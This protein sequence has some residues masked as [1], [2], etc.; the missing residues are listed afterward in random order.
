M[1]G[2]EGKQQEAERAWQQSHL[3]APPSFPSHC[4]SW[5][6]HTFSWVQQPLLPGISVFSKEFAQS[7]PNTAQPHPLYPGTQGQYLTLSLGFSSLMGVITLS[8]TQ[9]KAKQTGRGP[10]C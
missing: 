4:G 3:L 9:V 7:S 6:G 8:I 1:S 10:T 5:S 2:L